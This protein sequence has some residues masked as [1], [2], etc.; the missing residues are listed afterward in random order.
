MT[1]I[2]KR[3]LVKSEVST[4]VT[5]ENV[6]SVDI[7]NIELKSS[8]L[9]FIFLSNK[10]KTAHKI[11][12]KDGTKSFVVLEKGDALIHLCTRLSIRE[13][14]GISYKNRSKKPTTNDVTKTALWE[15]S[16][17]IAKKDDSFQIGFTHLVAA[18]KGD[19]WYFGT[20]EAYN[21]L[22]VYY[23]QAL[24]FGESKENKKVVL[25]ITDHSINQNQSKNGYNYYSVYKFV[26]FHQEVLLENDLNN[27]GKAYK[28]VETQVQSWLSS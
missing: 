28:K 20:I 16:L 9:P 19:T 21:T 10:G 6:V 27:L 18:Q 14:D 4:M 25:D 23:L 7:Q 3:E 24:K 2:K 17:A 13:K 15:E 5:L 22:E 8:F 12:I 26:Q 1:V 11:I